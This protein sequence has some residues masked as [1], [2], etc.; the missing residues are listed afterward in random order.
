MKKWSRKLKD[1]GMIA[2]IKNKK[3]KKKKKNEVQHA[4]IQNIQW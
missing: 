3:R 4:K 2:Q 1:Q